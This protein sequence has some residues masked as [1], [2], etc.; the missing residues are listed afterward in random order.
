MLVGLSA[1]NAILIVE[2]AKMEYEKGMSAT[3]AAMT[4]ARLRLR[5][6]LMT[7][8]AFI[9]GCV[10]LLRAHGAGAASRVS[11]GMVVV[12]GSLAATFIGIFLTP[13]LFVIVQ[14]IVE[15]LSGT[16]RPVGALPGAPALDPHATPGG[17]P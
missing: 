11:M 16:V 10:P 3:E 1:K 13:A 12:W 8:F 7:A 2:F 14:S 6:I 15:K 4:A 5:P 17:H 9:L